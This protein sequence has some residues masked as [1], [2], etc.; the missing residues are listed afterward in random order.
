MAFLVLASSQATRETN[1]LTIT[2]L[3]QPIDVWA[4][5]VGQVEEAPDL[6]EGLARG[7]IQGS[8]QLDD[9]GRDV[10]DFEDV[11]VAT[12]DNQADEVLRKRPVGELIDGQVTNHMVDAVQGL[13]QGRGQ[14]LRRTDTDGQRSDEAGSSRDRN[15]VHVGE[16]HA[17]LVQ[18]RIERRQERLQVGARRDLRDDATIA[19]I[20]IHRRGRA[21][22]QQLRSAHEANAGLVAG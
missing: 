15:R 3:G 5:R 9:V 4:A 12:G 13:A 11:R 16:G 7:V 19:G 22:D 17:R 8:T 1:R 21:V 2:L 18:R 20:L 14:G 10:A 6:V